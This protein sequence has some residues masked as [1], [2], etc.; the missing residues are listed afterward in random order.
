MYKIKMAYE[1]LR[2]V[3]TSLMLQSL[4]TTIHTTYTTTLLEGTA[5]INTKSVNVEN[6]KSYNSNE[7][8]GRSPMR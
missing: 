1:F 8:L 5:V 3:G 4:I 7:T 2:L 6:A